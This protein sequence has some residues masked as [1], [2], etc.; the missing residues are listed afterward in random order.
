MI[1]VIKPDALGQRRMQ[2]G[3]VVGLVDRAESGS[4]RA[5]ARVAVYLQIEDLYR[6]RVSGLRALHV[7]RPGQRIVSRG[8]AER[9]ARL[10]Q[11]VAKAVQRIGIQNVTRLQT[12]NWFS[13]GKKI[14]H[15]GFGSGVVDH[16][17]SQRGTCQQHNRKNASVHGPSD[18][19]RDCRD[20]NRGRVPHPCRVLCD[21][22]GDLILFKAES[23]FGKG[24]F[25]LCSPVPS[26]VNALVS[27]AHRITG[28]SRG[29]R[30][31]SCRTSAADG[32]CWYPEK[33]IR[34]L[35]RNMPARTASDPK[36]AD[37][38]PNAQLARARSRNQSDRRSAIRSR[39]SAEPISCVPPPFARSYSVSPK[40]LAAPDA[41]S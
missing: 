32:S 9:V 30:S 31:A 14:L 16:V 21:R 26:V 24:S 29:S 36:P 7:K 23:T 15:V 41:G 4:E 40:R 17:L 35:S 8:H 33:T 3:S 10:L 39:P 6:Q 38:P 18:E 34:K 20:C 11:P 28:P 25:P 2:H 19:M 27:A 37:R 5:H 1:D 22:V 13:R 12:Q